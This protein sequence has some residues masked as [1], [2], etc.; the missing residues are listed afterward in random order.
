M[1]VRLVVVFV[2]RAVDLAR[3]YIGESGVL[4]RDEW[5][6]F[7]LGKAVGT[8]SFR[9][10]LDLAPGRIQWWILTLRGLA[11]PVHS[12]RRLLALVAVS[13]CHAGLA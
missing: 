13:G 6:Q 5:F 12:F 3:A 9:C 1:R 11:K 2:E 8:R 10:G 4:G 7:V